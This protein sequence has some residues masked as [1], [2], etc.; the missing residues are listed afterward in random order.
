YYVEFNKIKFVNAPLERFIHHNQVEADSIIISN[1]DLKIYLDKSTE[2]R[3]ADKSGSYPHLKLAK[4]PLS[5]LVRH[6][7]LNKASV[8][9]TEKNGKSGLEGNVALNDVD[10]HIKNITNRR[11]IINQNPL[12][13]ATAKGKILGTSIIEAGFKFYLDSSNGRFDMNGNI[14]N[15][16]ES[17]L[18]QISTPLA[19][20]E[21]PSVN[22]SKL[23]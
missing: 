7:V 19:N 17:Q 8:L 21:L 16:N 23:T 6:I 3:F 2:R 4:S 10:I 13:I 14:Q 20:I 5:I 9:Y 18:N 15:I 12:C 11:S 1:P 22:I